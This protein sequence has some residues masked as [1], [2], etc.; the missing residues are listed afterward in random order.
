MPIGFEYLNDP[1]AIESESFAEIRR[2]TNLDRFDPKARQVAMRLVHS[3]GEPNIVEALHIS[4][5]AVARGIGAMWKR[6]PVLCDVE[7]LRHGLTRRFI[8]SD[9]LCFLHAK[10]VGSRARARGETRSM[11]ALHH[12]TPHLAGAIAVVGNAPTALFRLMEMLESGAPRP[13]II[14]GMPV[15]FV[16]AAESKSA[17]IEFAP[18]HG[19]PCITLAGRRGGS[20]LAAATVNALARLAR[21]IEL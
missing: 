15:G 2:L 5:D 21:G 7:M 11:A 6:A 19:I 17:L 9:I 16:G 4:H 13:A 18:R 3:C 10:D 14:I 1:K 8:D 12:W 20:A